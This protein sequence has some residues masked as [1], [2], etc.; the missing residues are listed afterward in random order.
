MIRR[1]RGLSVAWTLL[2]GSLLATPTL[3]ADPLPV[4]VALRGELSPDGASASIRVTV[5][6]RAERAGSPGTLEVYLSADG[7]VDPHDA[8]LAQQVLAPLAPN[9]RIN[10]DLTPAV[11]PQPPGRYYLV[12]RVVPPADRATSATDAL[13]GAPMAIGP[14]LSIED[15]HVETGDEGIVLSGRVANRGTQVAAS[16]ALGASWA[17]RDGATGRRAVETSTFPGLS[18]GG[19][20][21]FEWSI[22]GGEL[23]P[24]EY[25][26]SVE[27][28]PDRVI[29]ESDDENNRAA[30]DVIYAAGP[31]LVIT[32]LSARQD[33]GAIVV[34]DAAVNRG[35]RPSDAC[36][37]LFFL[38]RNGR[39]DADDVSL[40][41]RIVPSL[42]PDAASAAD[43]RFTL[44]ERGLATGRYFLL[45][46]VDG[47]NHVAESRETNNLTLA[48]SPVDVR[49]LP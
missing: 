33:G 28:D 38:S 8:R 14:D 23:P 36:G 2:A 21:A 42:D 34:H 29:A 47:S 31:D 39:W 11:P 41:Y 17:A 18:P 19:V 49:L 44:P 27:V 46:K 43:T 25:G 37:V 1:R 7:L 20:A 30:S 24:G 45:G 12:A 10:V 13:W 15:L 5:A 9:T 48:P 4:P 32:E 40:G 22:T 26:V 16:G 6:N 3:A 35:N